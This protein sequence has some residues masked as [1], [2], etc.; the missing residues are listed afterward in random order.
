MKIVTYMWMMRLVFIF[1]SIQASSAYS[2]ETNRLAVEAGSSVVILAPTVK[3]IAVGN[4]NI[5]QANAMNGKEVLVFGK[6]KGSTTI[7][8]WFSNGKRVSYQIVVTPEGMKRIHE[9]LTQLLKTIPNAQALIAGDKVVIQG[10]DLSDADRSKI[11]NISKLYPDVIDFSSQQ[12]WDRM[13]LLDVQVI[14]IPTTRMQD[15]GVRW[16][17][18]STGGM[19]TGIA[20][21]ASSSNILQRAGEA[22]LDVA[23]PTKHVAGM[24]G[25][26]ALLNARIAALSKSGEAVV[27]AQPQLLTRSGSTASFLAGGE[28]P[29]AT[30][31]KEGR[32]ITTF[33]QYGV[34]LNITPRADRL[35]AI[36]SKL[37]IEVSSVDATISVPGGPALKVRRAS[38]EFNVRSGQTLVVG[39]FLSREKTIDREG[40]PGVSNLP[41]LGRLFSAE[42]EQ[43]RQ[44]ELAIFVTPVVVDADDPQMVMRATKGNAILSDTFKEPARLINSYT[45][46]QPAVSP[47]HYSGK[48]SQ[49]EDLPLETTAQQTETDPSQPNTSHP[50]TGRS[51]TS[52]WEQ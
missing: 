21:E 11:S 41:V 23:Y 48:H 32:S 33:R 52:Q 3:R 17:P 15:L 4:G 10:E 28:V 45:K 35:G 29:Y 9:E 24:F 18:S 38:T 47:N 26:N 14:E 49:W 25:L 50:N 36:R 1:L 8:L 20:W 12:G 22:A 37:E 42:R 39:G 31:D 30:V 19:Q 5:V 13:V 40:V 16:D 51:N 46:D 27:L 2:K 7:D 44:T 6:S 34:S 43:A